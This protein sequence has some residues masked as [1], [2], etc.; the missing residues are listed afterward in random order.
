MSAIKRIQAGIG[1]TWAVL[2]VAIVLATFVGLGFWEKALATG[3]GLHVSPRFSGGEIRQTLDHGTYRTLLR[4]TV[5]DGLLGDRESGFVQIDWVPK[6]TGVLPAILEEALDLDGDGSVDVR[7]RLENQTATLLSRAPW[8]LD[9]DPV[10]AAGSERILRLNL[11]RSR[12]NG[13]LSKK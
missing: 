10:I 12:T 3:T 2:C 9:P 8:V 6:K 11:V 7:V 5:F 13:G 1:Y 4:R